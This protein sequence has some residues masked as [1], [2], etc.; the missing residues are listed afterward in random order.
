MRY[1]NLHPIDFRYQTEEMGKLF[2]EEHK[3]ALWLQVEA[4]LAEVHAELGNIPREAAIEIKKK[5]TL[6]YV[7]VDRVKEIEAEIHHDLMAM[8][9]ALTEVCEGDAGK[10]IHIGATSYDIEDPAQMIMLMDG[11]KVIEKRLRTLLLILVKNAEDSKDRVCVGRTHGQQAIPTT[12]GMRFAVWAAEM[13]RHIDRLEEIYGRTA[14]GKFSGAVGTMDAY[15]DQGFEIQK[16]V[17]EKLNLRPVL[18]ANQVL[19]RDR[20]AEI[21]MQ[22]ALIAATLDKIAREQRVLQRTEVGEM[23]EPFKKSQVGSSAM[24]HKRNPH[25]SER[26]CGLARVIKSNVS[27]ALEN[28]SLEDER[29][30]TNSA[31]E[32]V[33]FAETFVLLDF[34][35]TQAEKLL[36]GVMFNEKNI[37]R[38][39]ELTKG[40]IFTAKIMIKLVEKGIGRQDAHEILRNAAIQS[41]EDDRHL[42]EILM[43]DSE[44]GNLFTPEEWDALF[45]PENYIGTAKEQV[46]RVCATLR[47]KYDLP[48]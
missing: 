7:K 32:R 48:N 9:R 47:E 23:F 10:Y 3:L 18:I 5:A 42:K 19:Q 15:P 41:R 4:A 26:I 2:T 6:E 16:R 28:V 38:N 33:L 25:K 35:L 1:T 30:L 13:G 36:Q 21:I 11:L 27:I 8:V 43:A 24:P 17:L 20:H 12:Y 40:G 44:V 46:K 37:R 31:S 14:V 45:L 29:D 34:M 39:L 22:L